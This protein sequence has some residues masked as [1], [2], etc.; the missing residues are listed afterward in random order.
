ML[1]KEFGN[2]NNP[3][4]CLLHGGGLSWWSYQPI[5]DLLINDYHILC[6]IIEG[7]G[8]AGKEEFTTIEDSANHLIKILDDRYNGHIHLL[9]GLSIG[10]QIVVEVLSSRPNIADKVI[11][12]SALVYPIP[13]TKLLVGPSFK[14]FYGLIKQRWFSKLQAKTLFVSDALFETYYQDSLLMSCNSLVNMSLSNGTYQLKDTL[15]NV[16]VPI[17]ILVGQKEIGLMRKSAALLHT[18]LLNSKLVVLPNMGHG[19]L[20]LVQ[21]KQYVK[22]LLDFLNN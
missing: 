7:H 21:P 15:A 13:G 11:I 5:I 6:P 4:L 22:M 17:L 10:A 14:L 2:P 19:E 9:A 18:K 3:K 1:I 20:S 8:E 16:S 12:E